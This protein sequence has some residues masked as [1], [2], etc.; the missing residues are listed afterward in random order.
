M[1]ELHP[2]DKFTKLTVV[3]FVGYRQA[4]SRRR[5]VYLFRC[6]CGKEVEFL[7]TDV[8]RE[9]IK[10][11][12]CTHDCGFG[13]SAFRAIRW[14][15]VSNAEARG[16]VFELTDEELKGLFQSNCHYCGDPPA[17]HS[18]KKRKDAYASFK[19]NGVDRVNNELGYTVDNCVPCCRTC[20][21]MKQRMSPSDFLTHCEKVVQYARKGERRG[22]APVVSLM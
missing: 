22:Q 19:Y 15:Y 13:E 16:L 2:G 1:M 10:S 20:N 7:G 11:C 5:Q 8:Y 4:G 21:W 6:E 18:R 9:R 12:G 17:N 14:S 3:K